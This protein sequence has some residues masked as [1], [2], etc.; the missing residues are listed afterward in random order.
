MDRDIKVVVRDKVA[1]AVGDPAIICDNSDYTITFSFDDE[2]AGVEVKTARFK[3]SEYAGAKHHIDVPF[4]GNTVEVPVLTN[5]HKVKVGVYAG[6]LTTTTGAPIRCLPSIRCGSGKKVEPD[7]DKYDLLMQLI[8]NGIQGEAIKPTEKPTETL[9]LDTELFN[10]SI[11][12]A[13][14]GSGVFVGVDAFPYDKAKVKDVRITMPDPQ[15]GET[16]TLDITSINDMNFYVIKKDR[17]FF[18]LN[19]GNYIL[20]G[21]YCSEYSAVIEN[22][23]YYNFSKIEVE[24]YID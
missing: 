11:T 14:G 18:D 9:V 12:E 24:Y 16:V 4:R 6:N 15:T 1:K 22:I 20:F 8:K 23:K 2:W 3:Y 17:V 21:I 5:T 10:F 13:C 19:I 7:P